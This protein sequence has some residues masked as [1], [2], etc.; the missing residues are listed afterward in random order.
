MKLQQPWYKWIMLVGLLIAFV[1]NSGIAEAKRM[2]GGRSIGKQSH[3]QP[4]KQAQQNA[5]NASPQPAQA[6]PKRNWGGIL[7]GIAAG[8][9]LGML[10]SHFGGAGLMS[11]L[12]NIMMIAAL[13][14]LGIWL[15][16]KLLGSKNKQA[17][18]AYAGTQF[19]SYTDL[20]NT[21]KTF[22]H[23]PTVNEIN[24]NLT[25]QP[26]SMPTGFDTENFLRQAKVYFV[27][28][29]AAWDAGNIQDIREFTTPEMFAE[30]RTD[31]SARDSNVINQTDV[32]TLE[33]TLLGLEQ[34]TDHYLASVK[35]SGLI[36]EA[37]EAAPESFVEIWNLSKPISGTSGWVLAG[38]Q[39]I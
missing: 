22:T 23:T 10:L 2:G 16:R 17:Q 1:F 11:N 34:T 26:I 38:I 27:R 25:Q 31:L 19:K 21:T 32:V 35:F 7:G 8:L 36:R 5:Q 29:Q 28:L 4:Q 37:T 24:H 9:G 20:D 30:I 18:P 6:T 33:A 13:V 12:A 14:M 39:Q 3:S 15:L